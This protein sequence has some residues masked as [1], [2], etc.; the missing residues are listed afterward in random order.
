MSADP[1]PFAHHPELKDKI[2][3]PSRSFF[4]NLNLPALATRLSARGLS[5]DWWLSDEEREACRSRA[6]SC[7][8]DGD[9][10]VFAYGSLMWDPAIRFAEVRRAHTPDHS[11]QFILRDIHGARGTHESPG[12]MAALD[13][14]P[15][16]DALAFRIDRRHIEAETA[17][18][19]RRE[20]IGPG[21]LPA[22]IEADLSD[23]RITALT[24]VADHGAEEINADLT[25]AEQI[26]CFATGSGFLGTS[27][28]YL[29][30]ISEHFDALGIHDE[31]VS[32]LLSET[33]QYLAAL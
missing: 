26:R 17:V 3:D 25:R 29:E 15:G 28:E 22:F 30:N 32:G 12:L 10:W 11:R 24:F 9:L 6:L 31:E 18:L 21:Y 14:G 2:T 4:R 16:C 8:R 1:D 19:W 23:R 20:R 13:K 33:R 7:H 27:L 5:T